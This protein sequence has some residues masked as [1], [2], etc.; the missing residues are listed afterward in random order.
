MEEINLQCINATIENSEDVYHLLCELEH[1]ELDK[2]SFEEIFRKN[3]INPDIHYL[4]AMDNQNI[5]G[6]ASLHIQ[7]LLH[8]VSKVAEIQE[9]VVSKHYQG[10]GVGQILFNRLKEIAIENECALL[11]VCCNQIREKS[12]EFYLKQNMKNSHYKFTLS[13]R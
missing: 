4:L 6:F 7:S 5:I 1:I 3:V 10:Q 8:H 11:E 12:H 9:I 2:A 13:L